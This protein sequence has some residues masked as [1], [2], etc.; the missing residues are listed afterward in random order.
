ME[1]IK[2]YIMTL[3]GFSFISSL[4]A[5]LLP[6]MPAKKTVKFVC[7]VVLCILIILPIK[8]ISPAFSDI[9]AETQ[10]YN[11]Y[12]SNN[13]VRGFTEKVI[14]D[15][16][17]EVVGKCFTEYGITDASAEVMFDEEGNLSG[18]NISKMC[19]PAAEK[20]AA[21]LGLP[22]ELMHMTE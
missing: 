13:S 11:L 9:F 10:T 6:E 3:C 16:V 20:A 2:N 15:K 18:V 22:R 19:E 7:G 17:S 8:N 4:V 5:A 1:A 14:S 21:V 12:N